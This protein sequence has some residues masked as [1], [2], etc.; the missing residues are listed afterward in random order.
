MAKAQPKIMAAYS[1]S[2]AI[3]LM[4][5]NNATA[6]LPTMLNVNSTV[7][8]CVPCCTLSPLPL[9]MSV[10]NISV[11]KEKRNCICA[12]L[13]VSLS[14]SQSV[15]LSVCP[16]DFFFT[17][18]FFFFIFLFFEPQ[19]HADLLLHFFK[20]FLYYFLSYFFCVWH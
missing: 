18:F 6:P 11:R 19:L 5:C 7:K 20:F 16:S 2:I 8:S 1:L 12:C 3:F 17:S 15:C 14:V 9:V 4:T 10:I 13:S